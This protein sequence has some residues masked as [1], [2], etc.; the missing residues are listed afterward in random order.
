MLSNPISK[1]FPLRLE[2]RQQAPSPKLNAA[3]SIQTTAVVVH[4]YML[5]NF[6][7]GKHPTY[8]NIHK[9]HPLFQPRIRSSSP[10]LL[11]FPSPYPPLNRLELFRAQ[12]KAQTDKCGRDDGFEYDVEREG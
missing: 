12:D 8:P 2:Q 10:L 9:P 6:R 4:L 11:H 1:V 7:K 5:C 3:T